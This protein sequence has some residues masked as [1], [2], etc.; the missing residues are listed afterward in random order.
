[1]NI[2][3]IICSDLFISADSIVAAGTCGHLFHFHCLNQWLERSKTCPQ[4]RSKCTQKQVLRIFMNI[5]TAAD[6]SEDAG[7]LINKVDTLTL[8]VREKDGKILSL[9]KEIDTRRKELNKC[10]KT[11][12]RLEDSLKTT[13]ALLYSHREEIKMLRNENAHVNLLQKENKELKQKLDIMKT[14]EDVISATAHEVEEIIKSESDPRVLG[15]LVASLK[16]E[17]KHSNANKAL[18]MKSM[19][20]TQSDY[21]RELDARKKLEE[22]CT[23]LES[24]NYKLEQ[25][26]ARYKDGNITL[27]PTSRPSLKD[28]QNT[29]TESPE[30]GL[31]KKDDTKLTSSD[32][33]YLNLKASNVG[34]T[35]L[36]NR[37]KADSLSQSE[38]KK[39]DGDSLA[40]QF[41]I[42][43]KPRLTIKNTTLKPS[44]SSNMAFNGF[45]GSSKKE[46][47]D[48]PTPISSSN[49]L[50][51]S[52]HTLKR[53]PSAKFKNLT[54]TPGIP[55][56]DEIVKFLKFF[57]LITSHTKFNRKIKINKEIM[58]PPSRYT[59][60]A[61]Y[62]NFILNWTIF[63][64]ILRKLD[65]NLIILII[66][67][68]IAGLKADHDLPSICPVY[69]TLSPLNRTAEQSQ[70]IINLGPDCTDLPD[71]IGIYRQN[72]S[73]SNEPPLAFIKLK[74]EKNRTAF[75]RKST[76]F[77][78]DVKLG[79]IAMPWGWDEEDALK[80]PPKRG[81]NICLNLFIASYKENTLQTLDCLKI[82]PAWMSLEKSLL[83]TP[84]RQL[85]IPGSHCSACYVTKSNV[86]NN[87]LKQVG[88][89]QN[90]NIWQQMVFGVRYF[91]L[92]I[93][94]YQNGNNTSKDFWVMN[95][96]LK[97]TPL[98]NVLRTIRKFVVFSH[99]PIFLDFY[100]FPLEYKE[101][102]PSWRRHSSEYLKTSEL[103]E[104]MKNLFTK[105][106]KDSP[107]G[108]GWVFMATQ[109]L[110][111]S[112]TTGEKMKSPGERA[113]EINAKVMPML[114]GPWSWNA[115]VVALDYVMSTNLIDM[116]IHTNQ[117]KIINYKQNNNMTVVEI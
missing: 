113:S 35:P 58:N 79:N 65:M 69:I 26:L 107:N 90:L 54:R 14:V 81:R 112:Y 47:S 32:S 10:T 22:K 71:W 92:S 39:R 62:D 99:E 103:S 44:L 48:F 50:T 63:D 24:E 15:V 38:N 78:T 25:D 40:E 60:R 52:S 12:S 91:D 93:G 27:S 97:V 17:L 76:Q 43:K 88:F 105:K 51:S 104:F 37:R 67:G 18:L 36:L 95:G 115:N 16:R 23:A 6:L 13:E 87:L 45:G 106:S 46:D 19:K 100:D 29:L 101:L 73:L 77:V 30:S 111:T 102:W 7:Q 68:I 89:L 53:I 4:C 84:F 11:V 41:T 94:Y 9:E 31:K 42:F 61:F 55:K 109:E 72:P 83:D 5:L 85:F 49:V 82:Q 74:D 8:Q 57:P 28:L 20:L 114:G 21:R 1:M 117:N 110:A 33:P 116:A 66:F 108:I 34:L 2:N 86:K 56:I 64:S 59:Y 96:S 80:N 3:C 75:K 98:L 70:V